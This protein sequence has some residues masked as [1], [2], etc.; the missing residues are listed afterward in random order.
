MKN[1]LKLGSIM[2]M[3]LAVPTI[4]VAT[5]GVGMI[6]APSIYKEYGE[7]ELVAMQFLGDCPHCHE[8]TLEIY[9]SVVSQKQD[10]YCFTC[11][12]SVEY[13]IEEDQSI[14]YSRGYGSYCITYKDGTV[15]TNTFFEAPT[16]E[17]IDYLSNES[18][19]NLAIKD[20]SY[21]L[22]SV[23]VMPDVF[24]LHKYK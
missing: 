4:I 20:K 9:H 15:A 13:F 2:L 22:L 7:K 17:L 14:V 1:L 19:S 10:Q 16:Q 3:V 18:D 8:H 5:P 11:G 21:I 24:V 12:Y 6:E 23:E